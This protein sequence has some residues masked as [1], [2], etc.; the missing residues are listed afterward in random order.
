MRFLPQ[1]LRLHATKVVLVSAF[2]WLA[3]FEYCRYQFWRDP[4]SAFFND[5]HVYDLK[6]SLRREHE[7]Q[8]FISRYNSPSDPPDAIK[9]GPSP[10]MCA[11]FVTVK[12]GSD[13]YFTAS[14]GSLLEGL[15][16][17]ERRALHLKVLFADTD[18][19]R[20]S[21]WGQKWVDR[22]TDVASTYNVS[23]A[24]LRHLQKL[25]KDRNFYEKGVFDYIYAL[26]S[27][28]ASNAPY[29]VVFEDDIILADGWMANTLK[30]LIDIKR[31]P[32]VVNDSWIYLRLFYTE[33]ALGWTSSD[34]LYSN[35][36]FVFGLGMLF[37]FTSL[38][39][40]RRFRFCHSYLDFPTISVICLICVPAF[41]AL[42][43]MVGK[44]SLMPL[45]GVVEM[46]AFGCCT[47]GLVFPKQQVDGLIGYLR[48][49]GHG[50]TDSM[51]EE[52]AKQAHLTRYALAPQ[53]LQ[54]VGLKSS[55]DN[56]ELNTQSTWAFW[57][58]ENDA[59]VLR[60]EHEKLLRDGEVRRLLDRHG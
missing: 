59:T 28:Q 51:I 29:T 16:P 15:D 48:E 41:T 10:I 23:E 31:N 34:F 24:Q 21:S 47:Q 2:L 17:R 56:T 54:H 26:A 22:L 46:N 42:V 40:V 45:R 38:M 58:E 35:M 49:R 3:A 44:Y 32:L 39:A 30:A 7:A 25:E 37:A 60:R 1:L 18:S 57:F 19:T 50:Q 52:Y 33:T 4:H 53:Q 9:G 14:I 20:H 6:Y 55:R 5:R 13:D 11:A 27:C 43:Y 8:H 36:P 12:R